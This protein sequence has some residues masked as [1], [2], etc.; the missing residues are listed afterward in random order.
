MTTAANG[1]LPFGYLVGLAADVY[2]S[3]SDLLLGLR[4]PVTL[5]VGLF[6]SMPSGNAFYD[7]VSSFRQEILH[8][9]QYD[10]DAEIFLENLPDSVTGYIR[11]AKKNYSHFAG[12]N[13][14]FYLSHHLLAVNEAIQCGNSTSQAAITTHFNNAVA[15]EAFAL[16]F[17]T[18]M[19]SAGHARDPRWAFL[20]A[21]LVYDDFSAGN[22][23][24]LG[25]M[26]TDDAHLISKLIH[27]YDGTVGCLVANATG[28]TTTQSYLWKLYGDGSLR[29]DQFDQADN[30]IYFNNTQ[31]DSLGNAQLSNE[32]LQFGKYMPVARAATDNLRRYDLI[33]G[34]ICVSMA[35]VFRHMAQGTA[36]ANSA[37]GGPGNSPGLLGYILERVP[38]SLPIA[39]ALSA[40]KVTHSVRNNLM[41]TLYPSVPLPP[42]GPGYTATELSTRLTD[43]VQLFATYQKVTSAV[44]RVDQLYSHQP[45]FESKYCQGKF[46]LTGGAPSDS[47]RE[48]LGCCS[49]DE[50][51]EGLFRCRQFRPCGGCTVNL[52]EQSQLC[53]HHMRL[54]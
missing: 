20:Y 9:F 45:D 2:G 40:V 41:T 19:F 35:D 13:L 34:L 12:H 29:L 38:F 10:D 6:F 4:M 30:L 42:A 8:N 1:D 39:S 26:T 23:A 14:L 11:F 25:P 24:L 27:D 53:I 49:G 32:P 33:T 18:D 3:P 36:L 37:Q 21:G 43:N 15:R 17:L 5:P 7:T 48:R 16:H 28:S 54:R 22:V 46:N 47:V 44:K 51:W 52:D 31:T 50:P